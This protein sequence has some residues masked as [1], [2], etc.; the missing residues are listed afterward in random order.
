MAKIE[1]SKEEKAELI[2]KL[3][4]YFNDEL[5][6][7]MG[8]FEADFLLDFIT[9]ELGANFYNQGLADAQAVLEKRMETVIDGIYELEQPTG[10]SR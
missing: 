2:V 8:Q 4:R 7:E 9:R 10:S 6:F 3:Q 1:F 5:D